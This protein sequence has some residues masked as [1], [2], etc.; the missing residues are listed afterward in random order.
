[1]KIVEIGTT[2]SVGGAAQISWELKKALEKDGHTVTMFVAD[3]HEQDGNVKTIARNKLRKIIGFLLGTENFI[4]T[5]WL[6]R[7]KEFKEADIIHCHNL[8]GRF[9]NL[10]TLQK[11]SVLKPVVWTLHDE[12]AITPHCACTMESKTLKY[13]LYTCPSIDTPPRTL[14][15]N[16]RSLAKEKISIY[17]NSKLQIVTP[18]RWLGERIKMT[19]LKNQKMQLIY[20]GV[21]TKIFSKYDKT[22]ARKG[23]GLPIDKKIV[24]FLADN[25][26][27]N[28]WKGWNYAKNLVDQYKD[29]EDLLFI[30]LG[31]YEKS[32]DENNLKYLG[33][34][35]DPRK[36]AEYYSAA[37]SLLFTSLAENFP[38]VILEAM[39]C[40][41]PIISF[42]VGGVSEAVAHKENGYVVKYKD[43]SDLKQG[44]DWLLKLSEENL[45][46]ISKRNQIKVRDNFDKQQMINNYFELYK[47]IIEHD[48]N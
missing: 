33:F 7:T 38:L 6:L 22:L 4:S 24:M 41:L 21:D 30:C 47:K 26:A 12:W 3:K 31:N 43:K 10:K 20:N 25:A 13:G 19:D 44:I 11:M 14:W 40:G 16:D 27:K 1:M 29:K 5:D 28:P 32:S 46:S 39:S 18:S 37:D 42:D 48:G 15:N 17:N 45:E 35:K 2:D 23:L 9:F 8:H 36:L 34:I